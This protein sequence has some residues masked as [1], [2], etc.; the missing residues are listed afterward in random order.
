MLP[1]AICNDNILLEILFPSLGALLGLLLMFIPPV[2]KFITILHEYGHYKHLKYIVCKELNIPCDKIDIGIRRKYFLYEGKTFNSAYERLDSSHDK[3]IRD[4]AKA[5]CKLI[6][7]FISC[8]F[9]FLAIVS[10]PFSVHLAIIWLSCGSLLIIIELL[11]YKNSLDSKI[12][13]GAI[14]F[15]YQPNDRCKYKEFFN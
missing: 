2:S 5:G 9:L 4:N 1:N 7:Q 13:R 14:Q 8:I 11:C 3:Y 12:A 6:C 15:E 10:M